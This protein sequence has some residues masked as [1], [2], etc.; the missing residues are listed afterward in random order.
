MI[1]LF[2]NFAEADRDI[3]DWS[4]KKPLDYQ[5]QLTSI[6]ASTFSSEY[7]VE[8]NVVIY[9]IQMLPTRQNTM[10]KSRNRGVQR[11]MTITND[12]A[13]STSQRSFDD[14][15]D[16]K[17]IVSEAGTSD[18]GFPKRKEKRFRASFLKKSMLRKNQ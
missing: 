14:N 5:K 1:L 6:S 15:F 7:K 17:S 18:F 16:T 3:F 2:L 11:S 9:N 4:G 10:K 13:A 12:G 8:N